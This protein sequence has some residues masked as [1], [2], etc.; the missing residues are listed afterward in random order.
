M[1]PLWKIRSGEFAGWRSGD[2]LYNSNG[3]NIGYFHRDIAYSLGGKYIGEIY[4]DDW[5]GKRTSITYPSGG[6]RAGYAG[7]A[8]ARYGNRVG[9]AIAG[10]KDPDF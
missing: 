5:I 2:I 3:D 4:R 7:V 8:V 9:I 6:S 1:K 10:W